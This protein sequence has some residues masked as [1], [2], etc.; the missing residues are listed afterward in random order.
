MAT[1]GKAYDEFRWTGVSY[2]EAPPG[3][4][5]G[6]ERLKDMDL[7]GVDTALVFAPHRTIGHFLGD[8]DDDFV[9]A[10]I[11]AYNHSCRNSFARPTPHG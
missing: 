6:A 1:P 9:R 11:D 10:G 4:Y 7:D 2:D 3:C 8:A 5:D